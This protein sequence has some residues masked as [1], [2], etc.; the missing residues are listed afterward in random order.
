MTKNVL[1]IMNPRNI[2]EVITAFKA[3]PI[4]KYWMRAY[5]E[6]EL[7]GVISG[8]IEETNYEN[9]ILCSDDAV[10][11]PEALVAVEELLE[12]K[13][14]ASGWTLMHEGSDI[15]SVVVEP[16]RLSRNDRNTASPVFADYS[17]LTKEDL[18]RL[19]DEF[20]AC[21][22]GFSLMGARRSIWLEYPFQVYIRNNKDGYSSD[23]H[24]SYRIQN[25][26]K[27]WV[28]KRGYIK[29][30]K[31]DLAAAYKMN[32]IRDSEPGRVVRETY[33]NSIHR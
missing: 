2:P 22:T 18:E 10:V 30:L 21:G 20:E 24:W 23:H 6:R 33:E 32:W 11:S 29:H 5:T 19:P 13:E 25:H 8:I 9:Y 31:R 28:T 16:V 4:D 14:I 27:I 12:R 7:E 26:H 17:F 15:T 3:L 1:L